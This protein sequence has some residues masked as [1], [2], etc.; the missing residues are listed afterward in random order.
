MLSGGKIVLYPGKTPHLRKGKKRTVAQRR[1]ER[2]GV[3]GGGQRERKKDKR[4]ETLGR[5]ELSS[6]KAKT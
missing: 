6:A 4:R 5:A 2:L 1:L 3:R